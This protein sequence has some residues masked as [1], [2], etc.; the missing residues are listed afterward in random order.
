LGPGKKVSQIRD[1]EKTKRKKEKAGKSRLGNTSKK[2]TIMRGKRERMNA[3]LFG[4]RVFCRRLKRNESSK[5]R[6][7]EA[8]LDVFGSW[9]TFL[10][11][12]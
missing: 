5:A 1:G 3:V 12:S 2:N 6:E 8:V 11:L 10:G 9:S 7:R 4:R